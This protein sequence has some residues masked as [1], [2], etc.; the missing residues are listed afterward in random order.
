[1]MPKRELIPRITARNSACDA[2][3]CETRPT[4]QGGVGSA[5]RPPRFSQ[6]VSMK[7]SLHWILATALTLFA[8]VASAEFHTYQIEQIFSNASGTVQFI[9]LHESQGSTIENFL[10]GHNLTSTVPTSYT[11]PNNLPMTSTAFTRVLIATEGFAALGIITPDYVIPNGF[12]PVGG[13]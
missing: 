4:F 2:S 12:I 1:N 5:V 9:V 13:G 10:M 7:P 6:E 11:F 3:V 8:G